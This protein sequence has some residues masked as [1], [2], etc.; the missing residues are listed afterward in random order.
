MS[1][2]KE[3]ALANPERIE[4]L[5][6]KANLKKYNVT[7]EEYEARLMSQGGLCAICGTDTPGGR[8]RFHIDH[9]HTCCPGTANSCGKCVRGLLCHRC[10]VMLGCAGDSVD[11][12]R[13]ALVYLLDWEAEFQ[14]SSLNSGP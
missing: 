9:D 10:N 13:D 7:V 12:L 11:I 8:G 5:Y 6:R 2:N 4:Y 3:W 14:M 1:S